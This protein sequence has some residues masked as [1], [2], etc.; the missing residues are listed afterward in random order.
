[1]VDPTEENEQ[2]VH[3]TEP[4]KGY[5]DDFESGGEEEETDSEAE[6]IKQ[7]QQAWLLEQAE[8]GQARLRALQN[9]VQLHHQATKEAP[10]RLKPFQ[11]QRPPRGRELLEK[12]SSRDSAYGYSAESRITTR[13][14]TPDQ[15]R[16]SVL[17]RR[18]PFN[19]L[20]HKKKQ[21]VRIND[22][23]RYSS[24]EY[25]K[26]KAH[27]EFLQEVTS[28]ILRK[29]IYSEKGI[30]A[31]LSHEMKWS[32]YK[33]SRAESE[34][35]ISNLKHEL[36]VDFR[37]DPAAGLSDILSN[38]NKMVP[39]EPNQTNMAASRRTKMAAKIR[40]QRPEGSDLENISES[41]I[42]GILRD[43]SLDS[44]MVEDIVSIIREEESLH[45]SCDSPRSP[46][47]VKPLPQSPTKNPRLS[48]EKENTAKVGLE[49]FNISFNAGTTTNSNKQRKK[50]LLG[51]LVG[52]QGSSSSIGDDN[53]DGQ[54]E[55]SEY[56][57][58]KQESDDNSIDEEDDE[59]DEDDS[60]KEEEEYKEESEILTD[61]D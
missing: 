44:D 2:E 38:K 7:Q 20:R 51:R 59:E 48:P 14:P 34:K 35:L 49:L 29:G 19:N 58:D 37:N 26:D 33:L 9:G 27:L 15:G 52:R 3:E 25:E 16:S 39:G 41:E 12:D 18:K 21:T 43:F 4:D 11:G 17:L 61:E 1:V 42:A 56:S 36:G 28:H 24:S 22:D 47:G 32:D 53:V 40:K 10:G 23:P 13:E 57:S 31:A 5:E 46:L 30:R 50:S 45:E 54:E 55:L 8:R 60:G 6:G